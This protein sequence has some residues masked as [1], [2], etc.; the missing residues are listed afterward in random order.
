MAGKDI[1]WKAGNVNRERGILNTRE[2]RFLI[3]NGVRND[4]AE[5][6]GATDKMRLT[7]EDKIES[8]SAKERQVRQQIRNHTMNALLDF[9]YLAGHL[10]DRDKRRI[11]NDGY[12]PSK[13]SENVENSWQLKQVEHELPVVIMFLY[14]LYQL[15]HGGAAVQEL[16]ELVRKGVE[17]A[18]YTEGQ[19]A[20]VSV[21]IDLELGR[22]IDELVSRYESE[23]LESLTER[24]A[25]LLHEHREISREEYIQWLENAG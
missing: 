4:F 8:G 10:E 11:Y 13:T 7:G 22:D 17:S 14:Q 2:R 20:T 21:D 12:D 3:T 16:E 23:G 1:D 9:T 25:Y 5:E 24:E 18:H 15:E 19:D 6:R